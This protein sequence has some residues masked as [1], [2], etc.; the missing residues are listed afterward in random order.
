MDENLQAEEGISL[1]EILRIL[2]HKLHLLIFVVILGIVGGALFGVASTADVK[3]YGTTIEFYVNPEKPKASLTT[4]TLTT[5]VGSQ[6]GV[7]GAYGRHVMDAIVKLL[8][9]ESFAEQLM[10]EE[11]GFPDINIYHNLNET[12]YK[13]A[14]THLN[15][16]NVAWNKVEAKHTNEYANALEA[17]KNAWNSYSQTNVPFSEGAYTRLQAVTPDLNENLTGAYDAYIQEK[18]LLNELIEKADALQLKAD[19]AMEIH[20]NDWR[21]CEDYKENL[22]LFQKAVT[23][24]YLG[25]DEDVEDANNLARSF[26]YVKIDVL[27]DQELATEILERVKRV[28]PEYVEKHM[29]VPTDYEGTTCTRITRS[30]SIER[31]NPNY[32]RTQAIKYALLLGAAAGV[33]TAVIVILLDQTD[34]RLRSHEV[35]TKKFNVPILGIIPTIE[36]INQKVENKKQE[37][38]QKTKTEGSK[39]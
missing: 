32:T 31:T 5:G 17:V 37:G 30:D 18:A 9:S 13:N 14:K 3:Y 20:L 16:A 15:N 10:L 26:I 27:N 29:I 22:P 19:E 38:K 8:S 34:K 24:S 12:N 7:Y 25:D 23:Y 36:E 33:I 2:F 39:K 6:Y 4:E 35:L 28:V 11:D 1:L 21:N